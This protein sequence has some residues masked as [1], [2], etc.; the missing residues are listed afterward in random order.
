MP[1]PINL[2]RFRKDRARRDAR[3]Q[4]DANAA[5]FGR[6]RAER[7]AEAL[8]AARAEALV[9]GHRRVAAGV[10]IRAAG[11]G[12]APA[13]AAL[14]R[15]TIAASNGPDYPPE[16]LARIL[17]GF[18]DAAV[19]VQIATRQVLV[20]E[21]GGEILGTGALVRD[22]GGAEIRSLF[23]AP[24]AQRGGIGRAL[25]ARLAE[26]A[27]ADGGA[28]GGPAVV[29]RLQSSLT[30]RGFYERLG[31]VVT[32]TTEIAGEPVLRMERRP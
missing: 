9:A 19:A 32:A 20:A 1:D 24:A 15:T 28:D 6:T 14:I 26:A 22:A 2:N 17:A 30:A 25:M 11:P 27:G 18:D 31:F 13:V 8:R 5:K 3:A 4:A 21:R 12:D 23:V 16:I 10:A 7:E 29:L